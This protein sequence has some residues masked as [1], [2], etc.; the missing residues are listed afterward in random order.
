[1]K[2][3]AMM[4]AVM[5][6]GFGAVA[7]G[8][9]SGGAESTRGTSVIGDAALELEAQRV[10]DARLHAQLKTLLAEQSR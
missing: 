4:A 6:F 9:F 8:A 7:A 1:M 3:F 10:V 5:V 2:N